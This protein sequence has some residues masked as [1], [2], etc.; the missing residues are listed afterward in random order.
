MVATAREFGITTTKE[1]TCFTYATGKK[2]RPDALFHTQPMPLATDV[3][4]IASDGDLSTAEKLKS[5]HHRDAC[6]KQ[7]TI[8]KPMAMHTR[9]TIGTQGENLIRDLAKFVLPCQQKDFV[10]SMHHTIATAA[11]KGR[12]DSLAAA[13]DRMMW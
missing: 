4:L 6:S 1:P 11:A 9:G 5:D 8:F 13:V 7:H 12:A 10:R 2:H 3:T